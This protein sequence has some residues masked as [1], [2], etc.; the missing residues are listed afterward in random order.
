MSQHLSN[1]IKH[2]T[3]KNTNPLPEYERCLQNYSMCFCV[4]SQT[5]LKA[6][7]QNLAL[8]E[9]MS[10]HYFLICVSWVQPLGQHWKQVYF[11]QKSQIF[12]QSFFPQVLSTLRLSFCFLELPIPTH[13][14]THPIPIPHPPT[15]HTTSL[16]HTNSSLFKCL[17]PLPSPY[18]PARL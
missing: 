4:Q 14:Y 18:G 16:F 1:S 15:T 6:Y 10:L 11:W 9:N 8:S 13:T 3:Q 12:L 2:V 5:S 7:M 17:C